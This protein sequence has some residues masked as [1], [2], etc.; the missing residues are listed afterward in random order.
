[1]NG[2]QEVTRVLRQVE[3][4]GEPTPELSEAVYR[5]LHAMAERYFR[6][7]RVG[8]TLQ[9]TAVVHDVYMALVD[10]KMVNWTGRT[11]FMAVAARAMR[12]ALVN[13]AVARGRLKRGGGLNRIPL[14]RLPSLSPEEGID[15]SQV[16]ALDEALVELAALHDRQARVVDLLYFGGM[17]QGDVARL[18]GVSTRTV[19]RDWSFARAWLR[20]RLVRRIGDA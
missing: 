13:H 20:R 5:Q 19:E 18:L 9:P 1:M 4:V 15:A 6:D 14:E 16:P 8:H 7:E 12:Q 11:H 2:R 17:T 3:S 10:D